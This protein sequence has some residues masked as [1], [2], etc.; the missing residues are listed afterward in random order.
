MN[1]NNLTRRRFISKSGRSLM[2]VGLVPPLLKTDIL[3]TLKSKDSKKRK[4]AGSTV[5]Y[6][7]LGRTGMKVSV[8]AYGA[9]RTRDPAVIHRALDKGI[10]YIDTARAYMDG[11]NEEVVGQVLK[12][13]RKETYIATKIRMDQ[14][15]PMMQSFEASLKALQTDYV[16]VIQIHNLREVDQLKDEDGMEALQRMKKEGKARFIGFT[17]HR[18][19]KELIQEAIKMGFYD[20][21]AV[22]YNFKSSPEEGSEPGLTE[23][24][25]EA[26]K[27]GIGIVAMKTQAGGYSDHKMGSLSPHQ[28][29]LKWVLQ[30]P[31]VATTIPSM[32]T[33]D[34]LEENVGVM[35]SK[36][37]WHDRKTLHRYGSIINRK[38]CRMCDSC[39]DLC[40]HGVDIVD[41]NRSLMYHEG[42]GDQDLARTTYR[43]IPESNKPQV[44]LR[45]DHCTVQCRYGLS[46][47]TTM[48]KALKTFA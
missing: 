35:G 7:T 5:E 14:A 37:G 6:R 33:Y 3:D 11:Y 17:T 13:R 19:Q 18:N 9:M 32:V 24:I 25:Q 8:V 21:I 26:G 44:C 36:M 15:E 23:V 41:V 2:T 43:S 4:E 31:G 47:Q 16:D 38:L 42:Y 1:K 29:A 10:N 22:A 12:T 48:I 46:I 20:V 28:A 27:A 40:P 34:Q 45:C 30:N 39:R